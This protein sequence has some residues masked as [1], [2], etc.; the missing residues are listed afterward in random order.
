MRKI[1]ISDTKNLRAVSL[2]TDYWSNKSM[3][4][5]I[6]ISAH[7]I[8]DMFEIKNINLATVLTNQSH[9]S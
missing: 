3:K 5:F 1:I 9:T 4:S 7:F 8:N 2:T 6:T